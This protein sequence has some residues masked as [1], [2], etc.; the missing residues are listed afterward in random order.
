MK[1]YLVSLKYNKNSN[2]TKIRNVKKIDLDGLMIESE[3]ESIP[4]IAYESYSM[5]SSYLVDVLSGKKIYSETEDVEGLKY[6]FKSEA[7][8]NEVIRIADL[9]RTLTSDDI[10]RY[11]T[12]VSEIEVD[13]INEYKKAKLDKENKMISFKN[14]NNYLTTLI[15]EK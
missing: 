15:I 7:S 4:V 9:Y 14:A 1:Y 6:T 2:K 11:K 5:Y 13:S 8:E 3:Y 12:G 10:D